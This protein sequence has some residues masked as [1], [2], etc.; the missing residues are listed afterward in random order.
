MADI[1]GDLA[2]TLY[3]TWLNNILCINSILILLFNS[4]KEIF[5]LY[6]GRGCY[7]EWM[8]QSGWKSQN[9]LIS[10]TAKLCCRLLTFVST[11]TDISYFAADILVDNV[12]G[13]KCVP[14][15]LALLMS[16]FH[17]CGKIG[18]NEDDC[19]LGCC[20]V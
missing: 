20:A 11:T 10:F 9:V 4:T 17:K 18:R 15:F 13:W 3:W 1:S 12:S 16:V 14:I 7:R 8:T 6:S 2:L 19:L 5:R